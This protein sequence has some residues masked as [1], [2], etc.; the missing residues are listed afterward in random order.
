MYRYDAW[1]EQSEVSPRHLQDLNTNPLGHRAVILSIPGVPLASVVLHVSQTGLEEDDCVRVHP[2]LYEFLSEVEESVSTDTV[3]FS[4]VSEAKSVAIAPLQQGP[5]YPTTENRRWM[6]RTLPVYDLPIASNLQLECIFLEPQLNN[7]IERISHEERQHLVKAAL[8]GR[9]IKEDSVLLLPTYLGSAVVKV[10]TILTHSSDQIIQKD[11]AYR[12]LLDSKEWNVAVSGLI[13]T[14]VPQNPTS[15]RPTITI[16]GYEFLLEELLQLVCLHGT[17]SAPTGILVTGCPGVGK[18]RLITCL[19]MAYAERIQQQQQRQRQR[20]N[21]SPVKA[22]AYTYVQDLIF[23]AATEADLL[24]NVILP[25]IQN[26]SLWII[27]DLHFLER[28][29]SDEWSQLDSEYIMVQSALLEAIDALRDSC[30]ILGIGQVSTKLPTAFTKTGRLEKLVE[31]HSPSQAQ[32]TDMWNSILRGEV[33]CDETRRVWSLAL[34]DATAGCIASDLVRVLNNARTRWMA[35]NGQLEVSSGLPWEELKDAVRSYIPSQLAELDVKKGVHDA[36]LS[37]RDVHRES[38]SG[39]G[40]Y[41]KVKNDIFRQVVVPWKRFLQ[42]TDSKS[43]LDPPT[44]VLFHGHSG[45]GKTEAA[46]CLANSLG[47]SIV[48]VKASDILDKWLGGSEA[49]LR[50]LF[51]KAR[52]A[53]P[54]ILF[55][56]EIDAIAINRAEDDSNEY[57]SRILS[58]LLNEMDGISSAMQKRRILVVACTNRLEALD[59][60]LLRPGRLEEHFLLDKPNREYLVQILKLYLDKIPLSND[61]NLQTLA[62]SLLVGKATGADVEGICREACFH[63]FRYENDPEKLVLT[64]EAFQH[65]IQHL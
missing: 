44:G 39:F 33:S 14:R 59:A 6:I 45:C 23:R 57:S 22:V 27:D 47:V 46:K 65:V 37:W 1:M 7:Q 20:L 29:D 38:W 17:P 9:I 42:N 11:A 24:Q 61:V 15:V 62:D 21:E 49:I 54:C 10:Q 55:L 31:M 58:T 5:L 40:G 53:A 25:D 48:H 60:A 18:S 35:K 30:I 36:T 13:S 16:P 32:R 50:S 3:I 64:N 34:A 43:W 52:A 63:A 19:A 28:D 12:V 41:E 4:A 26:C 51:A 56:D 2:L 8:L